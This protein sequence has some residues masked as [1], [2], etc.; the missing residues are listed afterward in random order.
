MADGRSGIQWAD[1]P[2]GIRPTGGSGARIC[3]CATS[4]RCATRSAARGGNVRSGS[5]AGW[6]Y[7]NT[8]LTQ[9]A[10]IE[11]YPALTGN[12]R[13][14]SP[15]GVELGDALRDG[16]QA[17]T[18]L[19][20]PARNR[21][22]LMVALTQSH[23]PRKGLRNQGTALSRPPRYPQKYPLRGGV[24]RLRSAPLVFLAHPASEHPEM[25]ADRHQ[26]GDTRAG[27]AAVLIGASGL[28]EQALHDV[29]HLSGVIQ[30][31]KLPAPAEEIFQARTRG[32]PLGSPLGG[33][34]PMRDGGFPRALQPL[35]S[36]RTG[37]LP[38]VEPAAALATHRGL[39]A[40]RPGPRL[41]AASRRIL[42]IARQV[43]IVKPPASCGHG[44]PF[45]N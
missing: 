45:L 11:S 42:R 6:C 9:E 14:G 8:G 22:I 38:A 29:R 3:R 36:P 33:L 25:L 13:A 35:R 16:H 17:L 7:R 40:G 5:M 34:S 10:I 1:R 2:A 4:M 23:S 39:L 41:R 28:N 24:G 12:R 43:P 26:G 19:K 31:V 30:V 37:G 27:G 44:V 32:P 21:L 20:Q 15:F 18:G